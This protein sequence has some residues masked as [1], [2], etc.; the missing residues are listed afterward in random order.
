MTAAGEQEG[1]G[2]AAEGGTT[3]T[4]SAGGEQEQAEDTAQAV[5]STGTSAPKGLDG[6]PLN[7]G[8]VA[9][10]AELKKA[11]TAVRA[12]EQAHLAAA[13]GLA[14]GGAAFTYQKGPDGRNYAVAGEVQIDTSPGATPEET[15]GKMMRVRAAALAPANPS[16]QDRK[17]ALAASL[18]MSEARLELNT[19]EMRPEEQQGTQEGAA[20]EKAEG[21]KGD[22]S[23]S[24]TA[25]AGGTA[26]GS[27]KY[28]DAARAASRYMATAKGQSIFHL[29]V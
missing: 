25:T 5:G 10:L 22:N 6:E 15:V 28:A 2:E 20:A 19:Q 8:E 27:R 4:G 1:A 9:Q 16:P 7:L 12:H 26:V 21:E 11:D 3:A 29:A 17:V 24:T 14:K 13:G 18:T 23:S